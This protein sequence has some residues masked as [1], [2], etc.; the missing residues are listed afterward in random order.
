MT[1]RLLMRQVREILRLKYE[2]R[3][4]HRAVARACGVGGGTVFE[5][6]RRAQRT[7]L[8]W[9]L[10]EALDDAQLEARLFQRVGF[11]VGVPR[12]LPDIAWGHQELKPPCVTLQR[13]HLPY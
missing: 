7:G 10:L 4:S 8:T 6:C 2:Q 5:Y 13:L 9:P 3:L 12:P 1:E 11:P